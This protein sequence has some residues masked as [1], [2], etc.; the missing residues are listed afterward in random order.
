MTFESG[1]VGA[2]IAK[3]GVVVVHGVGETEAGWTNK[4]LIGRL[5]GRNRWDGVPFDL[6]S[7]VYPVGDGGSSRHGATFPAYLRRA[8]VDNVEVSVTEL[9]WADLPRVGKGPFTH[10]L[11]LLMLLFELPPVIVHSLRPKWAPGSTLH[12]MVGALLIAATWLIRGPIAGL[13]IALFYSGFVCLAFGKLGLNEGT[14]LLFFAWLAMLLPLALDARARAANRTGAKT[15]R[16]SWRDPLALIWIGVLY[17][18]W[19]HFVMPS[20]PFED[21][22]R[23]VLV[24]ALPLLCLGGVLVAGSHVH[25]N[26]G[27]TDLGLAT[28]IFGAAFLVYVMLQPWLQPLLPPR[29][30]LLP[31]GKV[32]PLTFF[33]PVFAIVLLCW[34]LWYLA[35]L[36]ALVLLLLGWAARSFASLWP[37]HERKKLGHAWLALAV[38]MAQWLAWRLVVS[39]LAILTV[40]ALA[41][42]AEKA[43]L[44]DVFVYWSNDFALAM[45][46][47][48]LVALAI[49][50]VIL[51]RKVMRLLAEWRKTD[52]RDGV[53]LPHRWKPRL[54]VSP[55]V[56]AVLLGGI[57]M[58]LSCFL[59]FPM[60]DGKPILIDFELTRELTRSWIGRLAEVEKFILSPTG[61]LLLIVWLVSLRALGKAIEAPLHIAREL[62]DHQYAPRFGPVSRWL[63]PAH[64][65]ATPGHPRRDRI[66][67]RLQAL[68][69]DLT[70]QESYDR[71][72]FLGHSQ[73][74]VIIYDYLTSKASASALANV[75]EVRV[76][77]LGSPLAH[78]Y[79]HYFPEYG[80]AA[81]F[82]QKLRVPVAAWTNMCRIDDAVG[83]GCG[84]FDHASGPVVGGRIA[85]RQDVPLPAGGHTDYWSDWQV[86]NV[87]L[88]DIRG[89]NPALAHD[90]AAAPHSRLAEG[91]ELS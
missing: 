26:L 25:R 12:A 20:G 83:N 40:D 38:V 74:S 63:L 1:Q 7:E 45:L 6:H 48:T 59:A 53:S 46:I 22:V 85:H 60:L 76:V 37:R 31:E 4:D 82:E 14:V 66:L 41:Q 42:P 2:R 49:W 87:L 64:K 84:L 23:D 11:A 8:K 5:Q 44:H 54:I 16:A 3:V 77:T 43:K 73:G 51:V 27:S 19:R 70:A 21:H 39:P 15:V 90:A 68:V 67:K 13:T 91:P 78:I 57:G 35:V 18:A 69:E 65:R 32:T 62:V 28:A 58:Q 80:G 75:G 52:R 88:R 9:W 72:I 36:S 30:Q 50:T 10:S 61:L 47:A 55:L 29:L 17:I 89:K 33:P 34:L 24:T 71:I 79:C 56:I 81:N 86:R